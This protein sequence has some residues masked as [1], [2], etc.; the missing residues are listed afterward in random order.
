M[1]TINT[2]DP[3]IG[4]KLQDAFT[5]RE[6]VDV[7]GRPVIL[8]DMGIEFFSGNVCAVNVSGQVVNLPDW[9]GDGLPPVGTVCELRCLTGGWGKAEVKYMSKTQCV[10]LW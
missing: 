2:N 9:D 6:T 3:V 1:I 5:S 7:C 8:D 4:E 10:W